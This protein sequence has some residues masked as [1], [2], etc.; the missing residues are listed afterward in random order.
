MY[1]SLSALC[2]NQGDVHVFKGLL[3]RYCWMQVAQAP[4]SSPASS[5]HK[6]VVHSE[7]LILDILWVHSWSCFFSLASMNSISVLSALSR[8]REL[9]SESLISVLQSEQS[10][11]KED[12]II[13]KRNK[14]SSWSFTV[15][16]KAENNNRWKPKWN[17]VYSSSIHSNFSPPCKD[18]FSNMSFGRDSLL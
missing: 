8:K 17:S 3:I 16:W 10:H 7:N 1:C 11:M 13:S 12:C 5:L 18:T 14:F 9:S 15:K 6:S 4:S 2:T